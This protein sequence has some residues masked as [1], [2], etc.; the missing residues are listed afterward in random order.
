MKISPVHRTK[1]DSSFV[2]E[3]FHRKSY[4]DPY[5]GVE[6]KVGVRFVVLLAG[7]VKLVGQGSANAASRYQR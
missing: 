3:A 2:D 1:G 4:A 7:D 6:D 5:A